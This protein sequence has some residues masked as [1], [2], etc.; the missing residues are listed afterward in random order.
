MQQNPL[1]LYSF[2]GRMSSIQ[3]V[4]EFSLTQYQYLEIDKKH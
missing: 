1:G 2:K 4:S 3:K